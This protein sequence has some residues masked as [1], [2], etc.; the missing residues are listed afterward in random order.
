MNT[1]HNNDLSLIE[2]STSTFYN[3]IDKSNIETPTLMFQAHKEESLFTEINTNKPKHLHFSKYINNKKDIGGTMTSENEDMEEIL[4]RFSKT[5]FATDASYDSDGAMSDKSTESENSSE[6]YCKLVNRNRQ[7]KEKKTLSEM[8][9]KKR[10]AIRFKVRSIKESKPF[11][12]ETEKERTRQEK[13]KD[14]TKYKSV[15]EVEKSKKKRRS[16]NSNKEKL[17]SNCQIDVKA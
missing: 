5:V 12:E 11:K 2:S 4:S 1:T 14:N 9:R 10:K 8:L 16:L 6:G 17:N 13:S 7:N 3:I 15:G